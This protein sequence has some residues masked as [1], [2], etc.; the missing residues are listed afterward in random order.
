MFEHRAR[1][2]A[3]TP[4]RAPRDRA[5][6]RNLPA[7]ASGLALQRLADGSAV[8][9]RLNRLQKIASRASLLQRKALDPGKLNVAG[10]LHPESN[11]RP[12]A[13]RAYEREYATAKGVGAYWQEGEFTYA[14]SD[15]MDK[16][17][18]LFRSETPSVQRHG[19][20][21]LLRAEHL[22]SMLD[23]TMAFR[24]FSA[25]MGG[26]TQASTL[27]FVRAMLPD[28]REVL[29]AFVGALDSPGEKKDINSLILNAGEEIETIRNRLGVYKG[30]DDAGLNR[31]LVDGTVAGIKA[32]MALLQKGLGTTGRGDKAI[33][34]AR[35]DAMF[36][37]AGLSGKK[38]LWKIGDHHIDDILAG[39]VPQVAGVTFMS[40]DGFNADYQPWTVGK[41]N[42]IIA[43]VGDSE[44]HPEGRAHIVEAQRLL[45]S[46]APAERDAVKGA[47][48]AALER[49]FVNAL[50]RRPSQVAMLEEQGFD[51]LK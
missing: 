16:L 41:Y 21:Y 50:A 12:D 8:V 28:V 27:V 47:T 35:S 36:K 15:L 18:G 6:P 2:R 42:T 1:N 51:S 46:F 37:A 7:V 49:W 9:Q 40:R 48:I 39:G 32:A 5:A 45:A 24:Q 13:G 11:A 10:E 38:G 31:K 22:L 33:S 30:S 44:T 26:H 3:T 20:P 43:R 34:K 14:V 25:E 29:T 17:V 19:D 4:S 23:F